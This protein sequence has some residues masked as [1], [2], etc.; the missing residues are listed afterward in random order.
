M[1]NFFASKT[2]WFNL[3]TGF[4]TILALIKPDLLQALGLPTASQTQILTA[5]GTLSS[6]VNILLRTFSTSQP[7]GNVVKMLIFIVTLS[8]SAN[9]SA[10][11][12]T[13]TRYSAIPAAGTY[14][15]IGFNGSRGANGLTISGIL[16]Y[17]SKLSFTPDSGLKVNGYAPGPVSRVTTVDTVETDTVLIANGYNNILHITPGTSLKNVVIVL[18]DSAAD[19]TYAYVKFTAPVVTVTVIKK[20]LISGYHPVYTT[21][22]SN[23][24]YSLLFTCKNYLWY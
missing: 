5:A 10:Q 21:S 22:Y 4:L 7:I 11:V 6:I 1:K 8:V 16:A 23:L 17:S 15:N 13:T 19:N 14:G 18:I 2:V 12:D 3:L 20:D 24:G 9:V